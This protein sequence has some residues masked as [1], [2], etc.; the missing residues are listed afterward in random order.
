MLAPAQVILKVNDVIPVP[1]NCREPQPVDVAAVEHVPPEA[2]TPA[3]RWNA[4]PDE[5]NWALAPARAAIATLPPVET[6]LASVQIDV[7]LNPFGSTPPMRAKSN[8]GLST[9]LLKVTVTVP[10]VLNGAKT[11]VKAGVVPVV[12]IPPYG[13][14]QKL[15]VPPT[16][17]VPG[18][19]ATGIMVLESETVTPL[20]VTLPPDPLG[21]HVPLTAAFASRF[22]KLGTVNSNAANREVAIVRFAVEIGF[23]QRQLDF[24]HGLA[25]ASIA[26]VNG[27][28]DI[29]P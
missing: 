17:I 10:F 19:A 26:R 2:L 6:E 18:V 1:L 29:V 15:P 8:T 7:S 21:V 28:I 5:M 20:T 25:S 16:F 14:V 9:G 24:A 3:G 12:I 27:A 13:S 23:G 11:N 22:D 4:L